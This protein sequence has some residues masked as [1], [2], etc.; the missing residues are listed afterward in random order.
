MTKVIIILRITYHNIIYSCHNIIIYILLIYII[1]IY[2]T[3]I[4]YNIFINNKGGQFY[5]HA[6]TP[7]PPLSKA[8]G[9]S[10]IS[11]EGEIN[12]NVLTTI[13]APIGLGFRVPLLIVSPWTKGNIVVSEIFDHTSI[14][15]F[16]EE[17]FNIYNPNISPWRRAMTG[18]LLSAFDFEHPDITWPSNKLPD[19][20]DYVVE[21]DIQCH[22]LPPIVVPKEQSMPK[23]EEGTRISRALPYEFLVSDRLSITIEKVVDDDIKTT[24]STSDTDKIS[25]DLFISN[26]GLAGAPFVLYDLINLATINPRQ[27][28]IESKKQIID[29]IQLNNNNSVVVVA[30]EDKGLLQY[31]YG[32]LGP[33]GFYR[34]FDGYLVSN[35]QELKSSTQQQQIASCMLQ[36][37]T[38]HAGASLKYDI[39]KHGVILVLENNKQVVDLSSLIRTGLI[40]NDNVD[41]N[42][43]DVLKY[44]VV[45]NAYNQLNNQVKEIIVQPGE[46]IE[47]FIDTS[48]SGNW[49][50]LTV[51]LS[52]T[53]TTTINSS[54]SSFL[55]RFMGRME[56]NKDT[57]SDPAMGY[58]L[59][60]LWMYQNNQHSHPKIPTQ[61][62]K[63]ERVGGKHVEFDKDAEFY[64]KSEL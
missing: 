52:T 6:W 22:T 59:P 28:A 11:V 13:P 5:D 58:G 56:T 42:D 31:S 54:S 33:N 27:Y 36:Q 44:L 20:T 49:Y 15:K 35:H 41:A 1:Y 46:T 55:R 29:S 51:T 57:I 45:D 43:D 60:G 30:A 14:V 63:I 18:N 53:T 23:Q 19:T 48:I 50:D 64:V 39:I 26:T 21:G 8:E 17:R 38:L 2:I 24:T 7:T 32:L 10:T 4:Y 3:Y 9:I 40:C 61:L 12:T 16:L 25:M 62:R 34:Q 47:F 37:Q